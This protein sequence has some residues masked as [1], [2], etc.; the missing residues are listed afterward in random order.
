MIEWFDERYISRDEHRQVVD[1]YRKLVAQL[2]HQV[3][4][5]RAA[6]VDAQALDSIIEHSKR[7]AER[8][9]RRSG[10]TTQS[11][12]KDNVIHVDFRRGS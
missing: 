4:T 7:M 3:R 6:Q 9:I 11:G 8:E 12:Q 10:E 1:Y 5:L 2:Y